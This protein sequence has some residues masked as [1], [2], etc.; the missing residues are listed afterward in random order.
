MEERKI[1]NLKKEEFAI[2]EHI[3]KN[4]GK[5]RISR[6]RVEYTPV[7][8]K[9]P[10]A[11]AKTWRFSQGYLKKVGDSAKVV[12]RAKATAQTRPGVVGIK[13]GILSPYAKLSDRIEINEEFMSKIRSISEKLKEESVEMEKPKTKKKTSRRKE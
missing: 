9:I 11:R 6:V 10:G 5:G 8:E 7:G 2:R 13:V 3:K 4:L 12:D 1:V